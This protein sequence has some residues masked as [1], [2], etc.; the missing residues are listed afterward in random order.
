MRGRVAQDH[1][2]PQ[3]RPR[4][5]PLFI[6]LAAQ[7]NR[8]IAGAAARCAG[9]PAR[10]ISRRRACRR[11]RRCRS[12][13]TRRPRQPARLWRQ[14]AA[15]HLRAVADQPALR[16]RSRRRAIRC[17]AGSPAR[18][19]GRCCSI[20]ARRRPDERDLTVAGH[21]E[22]YP[23][24]ADRRAR[25]T[26]GARRL[27]PRRHDGAGGG[28]ARATSPRSATD[29]RAVALLRLSRRQRATGLDELWQ[30]ARAGGR[31]ARR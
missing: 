8:S 23:A 11:R 7:R 18:A 3:H 29:R 20:G 22:R 13:R 19:C 4:P 25:R 15:G 14:R 26:P 16:A 1:A 2:A 28:D 31:G 24:A 27:L 21:V 6:D 30:Q 17:C 12:S 5:L 9:R 10:S